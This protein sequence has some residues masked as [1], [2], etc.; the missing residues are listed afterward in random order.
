MPSHEHE[1]V[2]AMLTSRPRPAIAPTLAEQRAGFEALAQTFPVPADVVVQALEIGGFGADWVS[3]PESE[4]SRVVLYLHG[5]GYVI[6]SN[7]THRELASRIAR[8]A[9]A[10]VLV[11]NYRLAPENPF[12]AAVDDATAAYCWLL[13]QD[14]QPKRIAVAGDS[15][16]G[17]LTLATLVALKRS[18]ERLPACGVC[19]SPWVDLEGTGATARPGAVDDPLLTLEGLR[20]MGVQY[21]AGNLRDPLAAPLYADYAGLP[22]LLIQVGT[23]EILLDDAIRV[24][25]SAR[26]AGVKVTLE[27]AEGL[28]HVWQLFGPQVPEAVAAI[29]RI[30]SFVRQHVR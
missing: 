18:G 8:A 23:R 29:D 9:K 25:D 20:T 3:V 16:G 15:A 24:T 17:G 5:G 19:M 4:V 11:I 7:T 14:I 22:P 13:Q 21:A 30:G 28:V 10:R 2:I 27:K 26:R 1:Q 6:G 12:P